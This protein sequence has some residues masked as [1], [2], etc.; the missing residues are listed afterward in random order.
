MLQ[1]D[2]FDEFS[3]RAFVLPDFLGDAIVQIEWNLA[4][5]AFGFHCFSFLSCLRLFFL[6]TQA[7]SKGQWKAIPRPNKERMQ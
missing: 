3:H 7:Y 5:H 1:D 6:A 4:G 2:L